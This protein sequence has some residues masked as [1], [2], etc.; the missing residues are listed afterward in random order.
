MPM[1]SSVNRRWPGGVRSEL[2]FAASRGGHVL[3]LGATGTGKELVAQGVHRESKLAGPLVAR[4]A[5]TLPES[6]VDAELFGNA[7]GYPNRAWRNAKG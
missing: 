3:I 6:L 4:N 2:S 1:A 7:R 5:A